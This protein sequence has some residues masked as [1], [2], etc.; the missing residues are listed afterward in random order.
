MSKGRL[1]ILR[2]EGGAFEVRAGQ[3]LRIGQGP[4]GGQVGDLDAWNLHDRREAFHGARTAGYHG[5]H[6]TTGDQLWSTPPGE[7]PMFTIL[8]DTVARRRSPR[9]AL[10]HDVLLGRCSR[11]VRLWRYGSDTPGCQEI[12]VAAIEPFGLGPEHVHD[13]FNVFMYTG[14]DEN[15]R[16]FFDPSDALEDDHVD[17]RAELDCLVA[18]SAC[19]GR[20]S[21]PAATGLVCEIRD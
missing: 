10:Q 11:R 21:G 3:V 4:G 15:D 7:R 2:G 1:E 5:M 17:L 20:S 12:L 19:P 16:T 14:I 8:E 18:I 6:V 9:G 13:A